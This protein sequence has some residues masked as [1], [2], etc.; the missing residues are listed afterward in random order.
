LI[1]LIGVVEDGTGS[2]AKLQ[3]VLVGG[4]TGTAQMLINGNYSKVS[5]MHP[6]LDFSQLKILRLPA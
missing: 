5:I 1:F 4:K 2:K 6:S 3:N